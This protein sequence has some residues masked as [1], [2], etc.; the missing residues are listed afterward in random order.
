MLLTLG[1]QIIITDQLQNPHGSSAT[2]AK[3]APQYSSAERVH[4]DVW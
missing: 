1:M 4:S 2:L 3:L